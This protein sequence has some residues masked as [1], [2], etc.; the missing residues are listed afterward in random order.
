MSVTLVVSVLLEHSYAYLLRPSLRAPPIPDRY[1]HDILS[2]PAEHRL[3]AL[4]H[5]VEKD[6][7]LPNLGDHPLSKCQL[8]RGGVGGVRARRPPV[9]TRLW[10]GAVENVHR[11]IPWQT[12]GRKGA[13][14]WHRWVLCPHA[15]VQWDQREPSGLPLIRRGIAP[16]LHEHAVSG[17]RGATDMRATAPL[18]C[19]HLP[20][21]GDLHADVV[22]KH[23]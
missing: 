13:V 1:C 5:S 17:A 10:M 14:G 8:D 23:D 4:A 9:R 22:I 7:A 16:R 19:V 3:R 20:Q 6:S 12:L 15:A 11:K 18:R 21:R 2:A